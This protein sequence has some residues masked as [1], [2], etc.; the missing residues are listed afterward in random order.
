MIKILRKAR[1]SDCLLITAILP[2]SL[3]RDKI[4]DILFYW[5]NIC[6]SGKHL[7]RHRNKNS[8]SYSNSV[9]QIKKVLSGKV[10]GKKMGYE[11]LKKYIDLHALEALDD[12]Y[13]PMVKKTKKNLQRLSVG[14][15]IENPMSVESFYKSRLSYLIQNGVK[16]VSFA[17]KIT[18]Q[19]KGILIKMKKSIEETIPFCYNINE[20]LPVMKKYQLAFEKINKP[21]EDFDNA[22]DYFQCFMNN[23]FKY[24][25][26]EKCPPFFFAPNWFL[27]D[28]K[29]KVRETL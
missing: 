17:T 26:S 15:F 25:S 18:D 13:Q 20:L 23:Y 14:D 27:N 1:F 2:K 11:E 7:H 6:I 22:F 21:I 19:Q 28:M 29:S 8:Q 5:N 9:S 12:T 24:N 10:T 16:R 3:K 4:Q